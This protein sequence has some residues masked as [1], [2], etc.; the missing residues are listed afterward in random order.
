M[1]IDQGTTSSRALIVSPDG[2]IVAVAQ[3]PVEMSYPQPGWVN[4]NATNLWETTRQVAHQAVERA[5]VR[6]A[7]IRAIGI[8][9]QRETTILW[10]RATLEP[11]AP[12]I[13]W[14]S[15]QTAPLIDRIAGRGMSDTYTRLTGLV[16]DAYF[17][18]TKLAWL[19]DQN[20]EV[21]ARAEAG[22][23]CFGTVDSWLVARL[24]GGRQHITEIGNASRTMLFDIHR[25]VWAPELLADLS[26]PM[27]V[28]PEVVGSSGDLALTDGDVFG[29]E[30][31]ICGIA[32]DQ[33]SAL[34]GQTCFDLGQMKNTYGTGSFL[35]MQTGATPAVS[36]NQLLTTIA[37]SIDEKVSYALEGSIFVTG[38]AISWLR[39]GLG[40]IENASEVETLAASVNSTDGVHFVPALTGLG[41]PYWDPNA[42]G[43]IVGLTRGTTK[44]HIARAALEGIAFQV[45]DVVN[46]MESDSGSPLT[47]LRVDGGAARNDLLMQMQS[48]LIGVPVVRPAQV[49]TTALGA[50]YLAGL[51]AGIWPSLDAIRSSWQVEKRFEPRINADER[52]ARYQQWQRAIER[53]KNWA[54]P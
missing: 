19:L 32:G 5:G 52:T 13:V 42:R 27:Q 3:T 25:R 45:C 38:A 9:N 30:I 29:A 41:A 4:Q 14:Q 17:S 10:D 24:S 54:E 46:A 26:I 40:I 8:T 2:T 12:A 7:D 47:E 18:A 53:A 37:W 21:R 43:T 16:P 15:R 49:E 11:V 34:F 33:Q 50:A 6:L 20:R 31:P 23:L 1:A 35:L 39:D 48:D 44:A 51:A 36:T 22:E 28:L